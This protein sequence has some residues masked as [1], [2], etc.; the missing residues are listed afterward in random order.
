MCRTRSRAACAGRTFQVALGVADIGNPTYVAMMR[1]VE[2]ALRPTNYRVLLHSTGNDT[3]GELA[4]V[5][6][7]RSGTVD[8]L[9]LQTLR[10]RDELL[11]ALA[12]LPIPAVVIGNLPDDAAIDCVSTDSAQGIGLAVQHLIDAG[13]T[14]VALLNG[15]LD[16]APGRARRQ[17]F[18]RA[19]QAGGRDIDPHLVVQRADFN[20][21]DGY[22]AA[23]VLL[24]QHIPDAIV[25]A[26]DL[27]AM[28]ALR[29][30]SERG[31]RIPED[32]AVTGMDDTDLAAMCNPPLTTVSLGAE[33][34]ANLAVELLQA[35][36]EDPARPP[37]RRTVEPS[38]VVRESSRPAGPRA[39][40]C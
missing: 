17:G 6:S 37:Q 16:T 3:D 14:R 18:E 8:G 21:Q 9:I 23:S 35:R 5:E 34:R 1:S 7:L 30:L 28:G 2:A 19:V 32:V 4:F 25:C 10:G 39:T 15:P 38:L 26:N 40:G 27:I 20:H 33:R 36:I 13:R 24:Q 11:Q 22:A 12:G 29:A 31:L